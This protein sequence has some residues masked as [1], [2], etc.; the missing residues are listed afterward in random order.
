MV[1]SHF[2]LLI[3]FIESV[4]SFNNYFWLK[5]GLFLFFFIL[6]LI[7]CI[8]LFIPRSSSLLI[9]LTKWWWYFMCTIIILNFIIMF[10]T[11]PLT[12]IVLYTFYIS[13]LLGCLFFFFLICYKY[14]V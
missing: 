1:V 13:I 10:P 8:S 7:S 11:N 2:I 3:L 12:I 9:W 14:I 6:F 5:Y 4:I